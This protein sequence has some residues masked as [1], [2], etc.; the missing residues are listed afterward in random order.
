MPI[1]TRIKVLYF[2]GDGRSGST[3]L[4]RT[5]GQLSS[6][7]AIGES[8]HMW[9]RNFVENQ[10][11][12]CG[13][14]FYD[15]PF[16][17]DV[18]HHA[19]DR[20]VPSPIAGRALQRSVDRI[21]YIPQM[22]FAPENSAYG[23]RMRRYADLMIR[24]YRAIAE[25]SGSSVI[26]DSSKDIS[27]LYLLSLL[28]EIELY[29]LHLVRDSRG[30]AYSWSRRR[31]RPEITDRE[32]YMPRYPAHKAAWIWMYRN[33]FVN[34]VFARRHQNY[35]FVRYEDFVKDPAR[36]MR[37]IAIFVG[38]EVQDLPFLTD[39]TL[40]FARTNHTVAGN[41]GRFHQG[42]LH[43][44]LDSVWKD[45]MRLLDRLIVTTVTFPLLRYYGY[46]I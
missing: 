1:P 16:W 39:H 5:L 8:T 45:K 21:R 41:P 13:Q 29:V 20:T 23:Q 17:Q 30:V 31:R 28:P 10:L 35:H 14:A 27:T 15:C 18:R 40:N 24:L 33:L 19:F 32:A 9:Q 22:R 38:E 4:G 43:L 46:E 3:L 12:G 42:E 26:V 2:A 7:V 6:F 25:I 36:T 34:H 11:C 37:S 44:R